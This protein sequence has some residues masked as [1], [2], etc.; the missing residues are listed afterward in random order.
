MKENDNTAHVPI[1][2]PNPVLQFR[3]ASV[4]GKIFPYSQFQ[5]RD[6]DTRHAPEQLIARLPHLNAETDKL[7]GV[8][9]ALKKGTIDSIS[10][11]EEGI[12]KGTSRLYQTVNIGNHDAVTTSDED[13]AS[14]S[15]CEISRG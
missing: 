15:S 4:M 3:A 13:Q 11:R 12:K 14:K 9:K 1:T 6:C 7:L 8:F 5:L 2:H 10:P